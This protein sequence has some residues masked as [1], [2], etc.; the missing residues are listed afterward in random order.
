MSDGV[1]VFTGGIAVGQLPPGSRPLWLPPLCST[2]NVN[3][4]LAIRVPPLILPTQ[5]P[6][7]KGHREHSTKAVEFACFQRGKSGRFVE[8]K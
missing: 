6:S 8:R 2:K 7:P 1:A 4:L 3:P 5:A